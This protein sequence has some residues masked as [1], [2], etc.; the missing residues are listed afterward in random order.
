M[1][2]S[3]VALQVHCLFQ[4]YDSLYR[5][6]TIYIYIIIYIYIYTLTDLTIHW[7]CIYIYIY[8]DICI[9]IYLYIYTHHV[10]IYIYMY[11]YIHI[12]TLYIL[13][14]HH[15]S[16]HDFS[17]LIPAGLQQPGIDWWQMW[18]MWPWWDLPYSCPSMAACKWWWR[19]RK[20]KGPQ[21]D[22][23]WDDLARIWMGNTLRSHPS[24]W[25]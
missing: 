19:C 4:M 11:M 20:M 12:C 2:Q 7:Y 1:C 15:R 14:P 25:L 21:L 9:C 5:C 17:I 22:V 8:I 13:H 18:Q 6:I 10:C 3:Q 24:C 16:S 23:A